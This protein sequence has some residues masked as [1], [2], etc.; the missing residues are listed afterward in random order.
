M[1][2]ISAFQVV[3][4]HTLVLFTSLQ[5]DDLGWHQWRGPN[6]NGVSPDGNPPVRWSEGE[7]VSWKVPIEGR[8]SSTP[9]VAG[10][11]VFVLT[12][13]ET[14][15]KDESIPDPGD[16]PKTNFFDIKRPNREHAYVVIC[17]DR[18][19]GAEL[20]RKTAFT[21]VPHE[22][23]HNDN[24]F[25]SA[26]PVTDGTFLYAWFGSAGLACFD[27]QGKRVWERSLGDVRVESSL[28]EGCSPV[29]HE[30]RLVVLR[31]NA[32]QSSIHVLNAGN[33]K[34]IWSRKRDEKTA[35]A[36]PVV[37]RFQ[38]KTQVITAAS[39]MIRS[40]DMDSGDILWQCGGLTGNVIP[41]P[42]VLDGHVICMSGYQGYRAMSIPLGLQGDITGHEK[43]RWSLDR[44]T[45]YIPSPILYDNLLLF[46]QSNQGVLTGVE[47]S[48]GKTVLPRSR[49]P[50]IS[51]L[52]A[53]PVG[54]AGR[55]YFAGRR[56]VCL[57]VDLES[58]REPGQPLRILSTNRLDD[59]F[60][61]S[62]A[63]AGS[64]LFLRGR[65]FLY[66]LAESGEH[67]EKDNPDVPIKR[68]SGESAAITG[69]GE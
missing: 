51:N 67:G 43:I 11:K 15:A 40:Y 60:N 4:V 65:K 66:C 10:G 9:I 30:N 41:C 39:R 32:G 3:V 26:S 54:A 56:G 68:K 50:G 35:W 19:S 29:L 59:Q 42:V 28:G 37:T 16:Q 23:V 24:D 1:K 18:K 2:P 69:S 13:I 44:G 27:L 25:A 58:A 57:V 48:S 7:N 47:A 17:L 8:G 53:S 45:P 22:G 14:G 52:Y 34:T 55:V 6:A 21:R 5:G 31:D 46:N 38:G 63:L 64:Q 12:T 33:G 62:P 49:L 36:T 20:W 61:A